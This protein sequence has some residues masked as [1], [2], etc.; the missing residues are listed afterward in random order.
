MAQNSRDSLTLLVHTMVPPHFPV[1]SL[2]PLNDCIAS[3]YHKKSAPGY[4][5]LDIPLAWHGKPQ[6]T[7]QICST[8]KKPCHDGPVLVS[9]SPHPPS[10]PHSCTHSWTL[11]T[12]PITSNRHGLNAHTSHLPP[13]HHAFFLLL[14]SAI[15]AHFARLALSSLA[16]VSSITLSSTFTGLESAT[17][18]MS[19]ESMDCDDFDGSYSSHG[20]DDH[21]LYNESSD[22]ETVDDDDYL[23]MGV[24]HG[25]SH[26]A[27]SLG[28]RPSYSAQSLPLALGP[29]WPLSSP[30]TSSTSFGHGI[31]LSA[32]HSPSNEGFREYPPHSDAASPSSSDDSVLKMPA[33]GPN[34]APTLPSSLS[35][36]LLRSVPRTSS[37]GPSS[38]TSCIP[39]PSDTSY[40]RQQA[41]TTRA[42][43][44]DAAQLA[45]A[46]E[47]MDDYAAAPSSSTGRPRVSFRLDLSALTQSKPMVRVISQ[48]ELNRH[49]ITTES[50]HKSTS[51]SAIYGVPNFGHY[52]AYGAYTTGP[53]MVT[54]SQVDCRSVGS[55]PP[56]VAYSSSSLGFTHPG[57]EN[58]GPVNV[59]SFAQRQAS[60]SR[61]LQVRPSMDRLVQHNILFGPDLSPSISAAARAF[62]WRRRGDE[63]NQRLSRRASRD[64]LIEH[65]ILR[66]EANSQ[67]QV[68]FRKRQVAL[69][70][71]FGAR[72][73]RES[74]V[75]RNILAPPTPPPSQNPFGK[76]SSSPF[77]PQK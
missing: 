15:S 60:L 13:Q 77:S 72:S 64:S 62:K 55:W 61:R 4:W 9:R 66:L 38:T 7:T 20:D 58:I 73:S 31:P 40:H 71:S 23:V 2:L 75:Q 24:H 51:T 35:S 48:P 53:L 14:V 45:Q 49:S 33:T 6:P 8:T 39:P 67:S 74:L 68:R 63:L 26:D 28:M 34:S 29:A 41:H 10:R 19:F 36:P 16:I 21:D 57:P 1:R 69:A 54:Q 37:G 42:M 5:N 17:S 59:P 22:S 65:N 52:G 25:D 46:S 44:L 50:V 18:V 32:P 27:H 43:S 3:P 70:D 12:A 76:S 11:H 47:D 30:P 56:N